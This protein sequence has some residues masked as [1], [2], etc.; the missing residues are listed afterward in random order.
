MKNARKAKKERAM[1]QNMEHQEVLSSDVMKFC[2]LLA[3]I[4]YRCLKERDA[5]LLALLR[6]PADD[7]PRECGVALSEDSPEQ[8]V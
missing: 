4:I 7:D 6:E 1:Q 2:S 8:P 5:H 3:R